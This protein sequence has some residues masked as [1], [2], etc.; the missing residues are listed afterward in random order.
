M[1]LW[2]LFLSESS[3][4]VSTINVCPLLPTVTTAC[5]TVLYLMWWCVS[6]NRR[7]SASD[8]PPSLLRIPPAPNFR[9]LD[10]FFLQFRRCR[11]SSGSW[12]EQCLRNAPLSLG[13]CWNVGGFF[14]FFFS[15]EGS[16]VTA[17]ANFATW[18]EE[19]SS[20]HK[21]E[22]V[23]WMTNQLILDGGL[24]TARES[25][26]CHLLTTTSIEI[27]SSS[28]SIYPTRSPDQRFQVLS[29]YECRQRR[30]R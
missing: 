30:S 9:F 19:E 10:P 15:L 27:N 5:G 29:F 2:T 7:D 13:R 11:S 3:E 14:P 21:L 23:A 16:T 18:R 1:L 8:I 26:R 24:W 25:D 22:A 20:R 4:F 6:D 17:M 12:I 28:P